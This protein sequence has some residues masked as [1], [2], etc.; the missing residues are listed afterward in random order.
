VSAHVTQFNVFTI[1]LYID[2][3]PGEETAV[4]R[5]G[6]I[7]LFLAGMDQKGGGEATTANYRLDGLSGI[8]TNT[9]KN[10]TSYQN[11]LDIDF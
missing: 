8:Q 2:Y 7:V 3:S 10:L 5:H 4:Q 6:H 1:H 11:I 9:L